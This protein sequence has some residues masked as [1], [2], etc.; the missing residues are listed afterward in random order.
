MSNDFFIAFVTGWAI[1]L[2][3]WSLIVAFVYLRNPP[4]SKLK[5]KFVIQSYISFFIIL[6]LLIILN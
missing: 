4:N 6:M 1:L 5:L 2:V 3:F